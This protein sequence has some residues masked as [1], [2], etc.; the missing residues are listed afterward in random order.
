MPAELAERQDVKLIRWEIGEG[1]AGDSWH[2]RNRS[3][4]EGSLLSLRIVGAICYGIVSI[5]SHLR[6]SVSMAILL[7]L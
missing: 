6:L 7:N 5:N 1:V 3:E 4:T 2:W